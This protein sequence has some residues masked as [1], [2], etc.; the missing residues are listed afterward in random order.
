MTLVSD[1]ISAINRHIE[2]QIESDVPMIREIGR[3]IVDAGGK[4]L[5]PITLLLAARSLGYQGTAHI[6]LGAVIEFIHT[7]TLLHD[8]VI[9]KS[10][11]R[12][13]RKTTNAVWGNAASVLVGDFLYSRAF[14]MMVAVNRMAVMQI[15]AATTNRISEGEV[16][17]L[18]NTHSPKVNETDYLETI[19]RK[20]AKLF[21]SAAQI[22]ALLANAA[23]ATESAL[24]EFGINIGI[25]FQIIDDALD[26]RPKKDSIG[27]N[28][29]DDLAD[30]KMTLPLIH[31]LRI[32]SSND[33][34]LIQ[35]AIKAGDR[36]KFD[37]IVSIIES[38]D[39]LAYT[40]RLARTY[41]AQAQQALEL[42][43]PSEYRKALSKLAEFAVS[44][45]Y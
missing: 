36:S 40:S 20:T 5:R 26:Y 27:K 31:A 34:E 39:S 13:G 3:Y 4:R 11:L 16:L 29:G 41:A 33:K 8:D 1:D 18:L 44:R 32:C 14:E 21:E 37:A 6:D 24:A 12:R 45:T 10:D 30:G 35:A 19:T 2:N 17:Q 28:T 15:M 9:D 43:P 7:A 25:S 42:L 22:G 38:T 23:P